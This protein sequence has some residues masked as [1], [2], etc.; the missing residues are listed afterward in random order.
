M[1]SQD[2]LHVADPADAGDHGQSKQ[3]SKGRVHGA[4]VRNAWASRQAADAQRVLQL[5]SDQSQNLAKAVFSRWA[6]GRNSASHTTQ[7]LSVSL[8]TFFGGAFSLLNNYWC[9]FLRLE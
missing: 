6:R 1:L 7:F 5:S 4:F 2:P 3:Y 8:G 9:C